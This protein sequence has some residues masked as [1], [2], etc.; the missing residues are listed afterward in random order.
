MRHEELYRAQRFHFP[1]VIEKVVEGLEVVIDVCRCMPCMHAFCCCFTREE[2]LAMIL[3]SFLNSLL[4][5]PALR[6]RHFARFSPPLYLFFRKENIG[7]RHQRYWWDERPK[8]N[9]HPSLSLFTLLLSGKTSRAVFSPSG[10]GNTQFILN[11]P[12]VQS[13]IFVAWLF[14]HYFWNYKLMFRYTISV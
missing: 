9:T 4:H 12:P 3:F 7:E 8:D 10:S 14:I 1:E 2:V 13:F 5:A 6:S 11:T